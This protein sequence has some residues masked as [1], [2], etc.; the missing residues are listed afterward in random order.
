[1]NSSSGSAREDGRRIT[2]V[3]GGLAA[4][5]VAALAYVVSLWGGGSPAE[6]PPEPSIVSVDV[7]VVEVDRLWPV[8]KANGVVESRREAWLAS[9]TGGRVIRSAAAIGAVIPAGEEILAFDPEPAQIALDRAKAARQL[10]DLA[11]RNSDRE[12]ARVEA[13]HDAGDVTDAGRDGAALALQDARARLAD[14]VAGEQAAQRARTEAVVRAPWAGTLAEV[15]VAPGAMVPAG[16]PVARL[17]DMN[18]LR[19]VTGLSALDVAGITEGDSAQITIEGLG[20]VA[21]AVERVGVMPDPMSRTYRVEITGASRPARVGQAVEVDLVGE[22]IGGLVIPLSAVI[23]RR[24]S[25]HAFVVEGHRAIRRSLELGHG[26]GGRVLVTAGLDAG[27]AL[28]VVGQS[29]IVDGDSVL[30][31]ERH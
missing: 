22:A 16:H 10:A 9:E 1:M 24:Q 26:V 4:A 7:R 19:V 5:V 8:V 18:D 11:L 2:R 29:E 27:D 13:L 12:W 30:V 17:V 21:A 15:T 14:A 25:A 6:A 28:V 3:K 20:T 31:R 23:L